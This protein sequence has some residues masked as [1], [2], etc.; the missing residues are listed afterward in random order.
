M[1]R[2]NT[3]RGVWEM[4]GSMNEKWRSHTAVSLP[5]GVYA[6]GGY[7]GSTYL[8]TVEWYDSE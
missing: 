6:L 1:E 8:N 5:N 3:D 4:I 2:Y 7:N